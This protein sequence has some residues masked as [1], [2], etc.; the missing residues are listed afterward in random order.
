MKFISITK[1]RD[2]GIRYDFY[3]NCS[4]V[5]TYFNETP[6]SPA[7]EI[8]TKFVR[9]F[10]ESR[11]DLVQIFNE[12]FHFNEKYGK[13]YNEEIPEFDDIEV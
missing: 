2:D 5:L 12:T 1:L 8:I 7:T 10:N 3:Y 6:R 4:D 9:R 11:Y 13:Y